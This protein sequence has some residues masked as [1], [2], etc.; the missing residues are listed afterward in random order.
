[1]VNIPRGPARMRIE[2][3]ELIIGQINS[4]ILNSQFSILIRGGNQDDLSMTQKD[5]DKCARRIAEALQL[6][7]GEKVLI[8]R[9]SR[10]FTSLV[11]PL[12]TVIRASGAYISG[13]ILA[14]QPHRSGEL[15]TLRELF[16]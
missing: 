16:R 6:E 2:N 11:P 12:E 10:V 3:W 9:D 8:K 15:E 7:P 5:Y 13:T 1:M 4:S 14:E